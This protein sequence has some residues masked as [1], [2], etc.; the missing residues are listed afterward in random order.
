MGK[1]GS[2]KCEKEKITSVWEELL[3][4]VDDKKMVWQAR[5]SSKLR[6]L[7]VSSVK[8]QTPGRKRTGRSHYLDIQDY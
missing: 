3:I 7:G 5:S 6:A 2:R 8:E 4:W 1:H